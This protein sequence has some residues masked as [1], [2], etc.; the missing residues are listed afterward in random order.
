MLPTET[1][2]PRLIILV[3][4]ANRLLREGIVCFLEQFADVEIGE[5]YSFVGMV[6]EAALQ[7]ATVLLLDVDSGGA[8]AWAGGWQ[9]FGEPKQ[10]IGLASAHS[11]SQRQQQFTGWIVIAKEEFEIRVPQLL[12]LELLE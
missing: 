4:V 6:P 11:L 7:A 9:G 3:V 1:T 10:S 12:Q 5:A 8:G 2:A